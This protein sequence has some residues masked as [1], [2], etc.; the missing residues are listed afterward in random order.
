MGA[1]VFAL[2]TYEYLAHAH[3]VRAGEVEW[4]AAEVVLFRVSADL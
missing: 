1:E 3:A 2:W 4:R